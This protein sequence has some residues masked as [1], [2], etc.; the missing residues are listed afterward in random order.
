MA[1]I[2]SG[3]DTAGAAKPSLVRAPF[4]E[5]KAKEAQRAWAEYLGRQVEEPVNLGGGVTMDFVLIPPGTFTMGA[6]K[7]EIDQIL[8]QDKT[9]K[10][11]WFAD[12]E[13]HEVTITRP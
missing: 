13:Q 8:E 3:Q 9:A 6:P 10:R 11:E 7:R 1:G 4:S 5:V 12:E 2:L